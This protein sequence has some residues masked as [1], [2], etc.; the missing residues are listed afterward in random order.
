M[1]D[2]L[3]KLNALLV[4]IPVGVRHHIA[5][6]PAGSHFRDFETQRPVGSFIA[7]VADESDFKIE[8]IGST[9]LFPEA[10]SRKGV[11][12]GATATEALRNALMAYDA[13]VVNNPKK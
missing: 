4:R 2:L 7:A 8:P 11:G 9:V 12:Y 10:K 13:A 6:A 5:P 3:M 1:S